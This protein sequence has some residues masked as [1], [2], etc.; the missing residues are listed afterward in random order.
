[1]MGC[2][3]SCTPTETLCDKGGETKPMCGSTSH[4][5]FCHNFRLTPNLNLRVPTKDM[6]GLLHALTMH[7]VAIASLT[8]AMQHVGSRR[9]ATLKRIPAELLVT[10]SSAILHTAQG[11]ALSTLVA[12]LTWQLQN[13]ARTPVL[14]PAH[15]NRWRHPA[16]CLSQPRLHTVIICCPASVYSTLSA[17]VRTPSACSMLQCQMLLY[18]CKTHTE[19]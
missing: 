14:H 8:Y 3:H 16:A 19:L 13:G 15:D 9:Y 6:D 5:C 2:R 18:N 17:A 4:H 7:I 10:C 11:T 12:F 1:M